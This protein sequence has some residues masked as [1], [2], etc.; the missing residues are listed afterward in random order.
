MGKR[1]AGKRM[2]SKSRLNLSKALSKF[3]QRSEGLYGSSVDT[4]LFF[5]F[6]GAIFFFSG[7]F[8]AFALFFSG[9]KLTNTR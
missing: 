7:I 4:G 8:S 6:T 1:S 9:K 2:P 3:V 5:G